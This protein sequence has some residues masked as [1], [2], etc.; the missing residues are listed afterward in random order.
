MSR[1]VSDPVLQKNC[2]K[3][4]KRIKHGFFNIVVCWAPSRAGKTTCVFQMAK[5]I[6]DDLGVPFNVK[7]NVWFSA[8][9]IY[10][11]G[12]KGHKRAV[13]VLDEAAFDGKAVNWQSNEQQTLLKLFDVA[14]KFNQTY[15]IVIP[16]LQTL[17]S[18]FIMNEHTMGIQI[19]YDRNTLERGIFA[20]YTRIQLLAK[21]WMLVN[22]NYLDA[23]KATFAY[24]GTFID[25]RSFIDEVEYERK[26][27]EA[28]ARL[29]EERE[30]ESKRDTKWKELLTTAVH[31]AIA[32][33]WSKARITKEWHIP[34]TTL[35]SLL[36]KEDVPMIQESAASIL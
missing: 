30:K 15:F 6:A 20:I 23:A 19:S 7:D 24:R 17:K 26:K 33:G 35:R 10:E 2:D 12:K 5:D 22:K 11:Q 14:G 9:D 21:Y 32:N 4:V 27:D 13:Y 28:I 36:D 8:K 31:S 18:D 25:D 34:S 16:Y 1:K 29:G 3:L